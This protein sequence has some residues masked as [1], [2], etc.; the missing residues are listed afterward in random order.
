MNQLNSLSPPKN[1]AKL[2]HMNVVSLAGVVESEE[3]L[4]IVTPYFEFGCLKDYLEECGNVLDVP[5][6]V[7]FCIDAARGVE[8]IASLALVHRDLAVSTPC[9]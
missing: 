2:D 3:R 5:T 1:K 8:Y 4:L 7:R 6:L 9:F